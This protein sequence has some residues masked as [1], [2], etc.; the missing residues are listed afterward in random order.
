MAYLLA[1]GAAW[2][3]LADHPHVAIVMLAAAVVFLA[4]RIEGNESAIRGVAVGA[5]QEVERLDSE[6]ESFD[7]RIDRAHAKISDVRSEI[8]SH[9]T[10]D[11][12]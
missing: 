3:G 12:D 2:A 11:R 5:Q 6:L 7:Q 10:F 4:Y 1:I 9:D 8:Y